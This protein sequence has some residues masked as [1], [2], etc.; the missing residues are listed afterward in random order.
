MIRGREMSDHQWIMVLPV[1]RHL[2]ATSG[3]KIAIGIVTA[4]AA[5]TIAV[6]AAHV[7]FLGVFLL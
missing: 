7:I 1:N 6:L 5:L 4:L 3:E 2:K